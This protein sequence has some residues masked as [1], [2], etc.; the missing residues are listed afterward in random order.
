VWKKGGDWFFPDLLIFLPICP[1]IPVSS[2]VPYTYLQNGVI[3]RS[4][5]YEAEV[6]GLERGPLSPVRAIE[7]LLERKSIGF[8]LERR[9]YGQR[10]PTCWPRGM[11]CQRKLALTS[12]TSG[13]R[14]VCIVR[15]WTQA[16]VISFLVSFKETTS[17]NFNFSLTHM[18][19]GSAQ[20]FRHYHY[21]IHKKC[22]MESDNNDYATFVWFTVTM[23][24]KHVQE[25]LFIF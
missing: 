15:S 1:Q 23:V 4:N 8:G 21:C 19:F 16:T 7:E 13:G 3:K 6:V 12:L 10:D 9:E 14:S 24:T 17:E 25:R 2:T 20:L 22:L 11:F 18:G 5:K